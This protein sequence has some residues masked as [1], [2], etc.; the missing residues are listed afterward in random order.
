MGTLPSSPSCFLLHIIPFRL[1]GQLGPD[2]WAGV[3][4]GQWDDLGLDLDEQANPLG[5]FA[6][7]SIHITVHI[8]D[9]IVD[10]MQ[11]LSDF[12][13]LKENSIQVSHNAKINAFIEVAN[14]V[15]YTGQFHCL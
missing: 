5:T 12:L 9:G 11:F 4:L 8:S 7:T 6:S 3:P 1:Q 14:A 10:R 13:N 15:M 2:Q